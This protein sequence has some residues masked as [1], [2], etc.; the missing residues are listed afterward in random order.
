MEGRLY[1][2]QVGIMRAIPV[3]ISATYADVIMA[4]GTRLER[5]GVTPDKLIL[6]TPQ[7]MSLGHDPVLAHAASLAGIPLDPKKAGGLFPLTSR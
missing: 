4:D 2:M 6:P 5:V 1:P 7:E 3:A